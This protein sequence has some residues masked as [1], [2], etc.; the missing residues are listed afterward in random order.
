[1]IEE[2]VSYESTNGHTCSA[3]VIPGGS[4]Y[5][6]YRD[7]TLMGQTHGKE[8]LDELF[9]HMKNRDSIEGSKN[10]V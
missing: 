9:E 10:N 5:M 7:G 2:V 4:L 1:M 3:Y 8:K 6:I